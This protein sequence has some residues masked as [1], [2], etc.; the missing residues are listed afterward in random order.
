MTS[1]YNWYKRLTPPKHLLVSFGI[2]WLFWFAALLIG[3]KFFIGKNYNLAYHLFHATWMAF[4]WTILFHWK[5]ITAIFKN[6]RQQA[7]R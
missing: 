6:N 1:V 3:D 2:N 5:K 7:E 4:F